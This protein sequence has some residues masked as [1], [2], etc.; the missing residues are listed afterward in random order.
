MT[1][2]QPVAL[3]ILLAVAALSAQPADPYLQLVRMY[4]SDPAAAALSATRLSPA[5]IKR[6]IE[7]W[8]RAVRR[9]VLSAGGVACRQA[10]LLAGA[11]LHADAAEL[12]IGPVGYAARDQIHFG[13][14]LLEVAFNVATINAKRN[15]AYDD[16][17]R[18]VV[19][20]S[21][22][23]YALTARLLLAHGHVEVA[24]LVA[25]EGGGRSPESP[26]L[27]VALGLISEWRAGL[28]WSAG[29]LRGFILRG[30]RW[31][32]DFTSFR[33]TATQDLLTAAVNY[34]R[35]LAI[36]PGHAGARLRLMWVHL[37]ADDRRAW[38]DV[39]AGIFKDASPEERLV[40]HL[41]R[42]TAAERERK[43]DVALAEYR[44][45]RSAVPE[46]QTACLAVSSAQA[47]AG[48]FSG[49]NATAVEC[50]TLGDGPDYVD[51]WT[52]F[53]M[54]FM[55][56]TTAQGLRDEANRP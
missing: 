35:A 9:C 56:T 54:G 26:D 33:G 48:D 18:A 7:D 41:L 17:L 52:L 21:G 4:R 16:D 24:K 32:P 2:G 36:D 5:V 51:P 14:E 49:A 37:I 22:R 20:F 40:A 1:K 55:D 29:D 34:R 31:A 46:S 13:R 25:A 28:D 19:S 38:D 53:R 44:D 6:G 45:A 3:G 15:N 47:L 23:W 42:G 50:L 43:A 30:D 10:D 27:F 11:M 8:S 39:P 12:V